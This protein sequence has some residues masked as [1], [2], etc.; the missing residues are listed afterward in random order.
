MICL[1]RNS[2][3]KSTIS[4]IQLLQALNNPGNFE[5]D[6]GQSMQSFS[7]VLDQIVTLLSSDPRVGAINLF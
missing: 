5:L 1:K 6:S 7:E 2:Y 4:W 3:R